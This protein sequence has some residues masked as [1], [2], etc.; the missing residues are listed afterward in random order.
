MSRARFF[1]LFG[2]ALILAGLVPV[3][4]FSLGSLLPQA[5]DVLGFFPSIPGLDA[6][7]GWLHARRV[8]WTPSPGLVFAV[9][10]IAVMVLGA[11][12]AKQQKPV[13]DAMR[14]RRQDA[15]RRAPLYGRERIE[16][17]LD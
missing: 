10:G 12:L 1:W 2:I 9:S 13:F 16:P 14:L 4:L 5:S 3:L 7:E 15:R 8:K 6:A 17:T 11:T